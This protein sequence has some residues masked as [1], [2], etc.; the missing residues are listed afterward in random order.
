MSSSFLQEIFTADLA[1]SNNPINKVF[2]LCHALNLEPISINVIF[3]PCKIERS[4]SNIIERVINFRTCFFRYLYINSVKLS[5]KPKEASR[6]IYS[7]LFIPALV[8][9]TTSILGLQGLKLAYIS[10]YS[11][12]IILNFLFKTIFQKK[13]IWS[14]F[15]KTID[16]TFYHPFHLAL[17]NT[18]KLS[19][20]LARLI[21]LNTAPEIPEDGNTL[22][23]MMFTPWDKFKDCSSGKKFICFN[24]EKYRLIWEKSVDRNSE[25]L[26]K[27]PESPEICFIKNAETVFFVESWDHTRVVMHFNYISKKNSPI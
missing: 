21:F 8:L 4:S 11:N 7:L 16:S 22:D 18:F 2:T 6:K 14:V 19:E 9:D 1:E 5:D 26:K 3:T 27:L 20:F 13:S 23:A 12:A 25:I 17:L 24:E 10:I 15:C